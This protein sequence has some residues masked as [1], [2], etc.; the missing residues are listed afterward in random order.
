MIKKNLGA[1]LKNLLAPFKF[2]MVIQYNFIKGF[3]R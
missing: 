2:F 1:K 3:T